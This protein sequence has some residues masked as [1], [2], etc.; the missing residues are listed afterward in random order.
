MNA[1][2]VEVIDQRTRAALKNLAARVH[3]L[4]PVMHA[5]AEG[6]AERTKLRFDTSSGPDGA[7]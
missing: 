3:N 5:I 2:T 1:F 7:A 6:I 4:A